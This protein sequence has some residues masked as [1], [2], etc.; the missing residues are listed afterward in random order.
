MHYFNYNEDVLP[1][2]TRS[3]GKL[4]LLSAKLEC[5]RKAFFYM[6]VY[7]LIRFRFLDFYDFSCN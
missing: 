4:R 1:R 5:T 7:F 3:I 6:V 2:R